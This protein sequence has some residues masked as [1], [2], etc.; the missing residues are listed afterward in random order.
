MLKFDTEKTSFNFQFNNYEDY[1]NPSSFGELIS[2]QLS[3][4]PPI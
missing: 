1:D 4:K 3:T 2:C